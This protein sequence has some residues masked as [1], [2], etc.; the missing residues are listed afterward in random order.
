MVGTG[1]V[2]LKAL[3]KRVAADQLFM[4]PM[5]LVI[6]I[7]SVGIMEGHDIKKIREKY[8]DMYIPALL[9]N[10]KAWPL[11]QLINF[12]YMPLPYRVPFQS[13]CGVFWT[14]Y[15]SMLNAKED[16]MRYVEP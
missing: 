13:T 16:K 12:R 10:W 15:L 1:R 5:G 8:R 6:F 4:A 3:S 14:L 7:G 2:S 9:A 11:A